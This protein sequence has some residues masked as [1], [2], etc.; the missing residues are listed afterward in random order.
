[1]SAYQLVDRFVRVRWSNPLPGEGHPLRIVVQVKQTVMRK[2]IEM[3]VWS[4]ETSVLTTFKDCFADE[5]WHV[6]VVAL[7][8]DPSDLADLFGT[9]KGSYQASDT[10][11]STAID[12]KRVSAGA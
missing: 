10:A 4:D 8:D 9:A 5:N 7:D 2:R 12:W 1:M 3:I 11:A 6:S